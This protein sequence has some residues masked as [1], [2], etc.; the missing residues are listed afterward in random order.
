MKTTVE[1]MDLVIEC[2]GESYENDYVIAM[3]ALHW[4]HEFKHVIRV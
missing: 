3:C 1:N 4:V 2:G